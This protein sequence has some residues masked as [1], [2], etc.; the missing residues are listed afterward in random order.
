VLTARPELAV[1]PALLT[2]P[3]DQLMPDPAQTSQRNPVWVVRSYRS[4]KVKRRALPWAVAP[5][6]PCWQHWAHLRGLM[7]LP[8]LQGW[9]EHRASDPA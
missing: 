8:R 9:D 7:A 6:Q 5:E 2:K 3:D 1:R 4:R